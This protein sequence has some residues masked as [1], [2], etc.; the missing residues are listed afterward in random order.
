MCLKEERL[1]ISAQKMLCFF[2]IIR[3]SQREIFGGKSN[4][5]QDLHLAHLSGDRLIPEQ[6]L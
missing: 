6:H 2:L 1:N 3:V 5:V 4:S